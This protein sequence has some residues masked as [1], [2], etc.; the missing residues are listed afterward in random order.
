M[1]TPE[2]ELVVRGEGMPRTAG[3]GRGDLLV[4][5]RIAFPQRVSAL[6]LAQL[7]AVLA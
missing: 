5:F 7:Q 1:I 3:D 6:Q 4:R 2:S